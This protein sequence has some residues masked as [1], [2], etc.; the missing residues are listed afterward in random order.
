MN[1][2]EAKEQRDMDAA[3]GGVT[4]K[5]ASEAR[6]SAAEADPSGEFGFGFNRKASLEE[7]LGA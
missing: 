5:A 3:E 4:W 2:I 6:S 1:V 7:T